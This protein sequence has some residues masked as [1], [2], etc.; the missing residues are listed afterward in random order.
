[1]TVKRPLVMNQPQIGQLIRAIRLEVGMTQEQLAAELGVTYS[2]MNRWENGRRT[3]S[4]LAMRKIE[5]LLRQ[6]GDRGQELLEKHY[7]E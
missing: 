5:E 7:A 6:M 3:P 1:M 2:S 4:P